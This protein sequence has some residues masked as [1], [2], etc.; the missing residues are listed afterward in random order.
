M[1]TFDMMMVFEKAES[2][3]AVLEPVMHIFGLDALSKA[4]L[5]SDGVPD[6]G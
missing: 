4:I 2:D 6:C 3:E 1:P 5:L